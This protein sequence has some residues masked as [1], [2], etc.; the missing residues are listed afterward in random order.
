MGA[1]PHSSLTRW[2][3]WCWNYAFLPYKAPL[4]SV[5]YISVFCKDAL[6]LYF[7]FCCICDLCESFVFDFY[8]ICTVFCTLHCMYFVFCNVCICLPLHRWVRGLF[9]ASRL[10]RTHFFF[11]V[12]KLIFPMMMMMVAIMIMILKI[13]I[14]MITDMTSEHSIYSDPCPRKYSGW[15]MTLIWIL[16]I[17]FMP[18]SL[19]LKIKEYLLC[20]DPYR[21]KSREIDG[22]NTLVGRVLRYEFDMSPPHPPEPSPAYLDHSITSRATRADGDENY[23]RPMFLYNLHFKT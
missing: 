1:W 6:Y 15:D 16:N 4:Y 3:S 23:H 18:W 2:Y 7:V 12:A 22:E 19:S 10:P 21:W 8:K 20:L 13:L 11:S 17:Y 9:G 14:M 5:F